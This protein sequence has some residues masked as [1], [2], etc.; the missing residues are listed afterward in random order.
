MVQPKLEFCIICNTLIAWTLVL[1]PRT[2]LQCMPTSAPFS[3]PKSIN[4]YPIII[5]YHRT[6]GF[7]EI[8]SLSKASTRSLSYPVLSNL[9]VSGS[10]T[11]AGDLFYIGTKKTTAFDWLKNCILF[12]WVR[13][14][15][16]SQVIFSKKLI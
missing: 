16:W 4:I 3:I 5:T 12:L 14:K 10:V 7:W 15:D 1:F 6:L 2:D 8:I 13:K 11:A 9:L